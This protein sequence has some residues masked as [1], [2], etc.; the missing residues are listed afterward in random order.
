MSNIMKK[1]YLILNIEEYGKLMAFCIE[2]DITVWRTYWD[3]REKGDRCYEINWQEKRCYYSSRRY[4]EEKGYEITIPD[5]VLDKFGEY[6]QIEH[7]IE[8]EGKF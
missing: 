5:F 8:K 2:N 7:Q 3:E 1:A 4:Y 6:Y